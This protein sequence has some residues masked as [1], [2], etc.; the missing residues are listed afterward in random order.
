MFFLKQQGFT[1]SLRFAKF[2]LIDMFN[3]ISLGISIAPYLW[4]RNF[5]IIKKSF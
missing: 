2:C 1:I 3:S 4:V 5:L